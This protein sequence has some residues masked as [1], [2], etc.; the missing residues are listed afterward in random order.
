MKRLLTWPINKLRKLRQLMKTNPCNRGVIQIFVNDSQRKTSYSLT[1]YP[2]FLLPKLLGSVGYEISLFDE[3]GKLVFSKD[4]EVPKYGS[5]KIVPAEIYEGKLPERGIFQANLKASRFS[6]LDKYYLRLL[7]MVTSHFY[8]MFY[9][10]NFESLAL[11]HPQTVAPVP[12]SDEKSNF[13]YSQYLIHVPSVAKLE[14]FQINPC[15]SAYPLNLKLMNTKGQVIAEST[16]QVPGYGIRKVVW[17]KPTLAD[18]EYLYL[19]SDTLRGNEKPILFSY[20]SDGSYTAL[21]T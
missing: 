6:L 4:I 21:H 14:V 15:K 1:N 17:E 13:W 11:I 2:S 19:A 3:S 12:D 16:D 18:Q 7:G 8:T 20:Y 10:P 5:A 9:S